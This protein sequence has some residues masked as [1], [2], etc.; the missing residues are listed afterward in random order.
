[1]N[2]LGQQY[3]AWTSL[4]ESIVSIGTD[5]FPAIVF[6]LLR[7]F[8]ECLDL[9]ALLDLFQRQVGGL[10]RDFFHSFVKV[11]AGFFELHFKSTVS[12][13]FSSWK[14]LQ[15]VRI[16]D[17]FR[18]DVVSS[19]EQGHVP[20][21]LIRES[22]KTLVAPIPF[23]GERNYLRFSFLNGLMLLVQHMGPLLAK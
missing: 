11:L 2:I 13:S 9:R 5:I 21:K 22:S 19:G 16:C 20:A 8:E 15:R 7:I 1:M 17:S 4:S 10:L 18:G 23:D 12:S 14:T 6:S 3:N